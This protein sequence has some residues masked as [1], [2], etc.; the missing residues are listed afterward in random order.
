VCGFKELYTGR[1][2]RCLKCDQIFIIPA[3]DGQTAEKV[4]PPKENYDP[5]PG[6]Y[7]AVFKK[8]IPAIFN[9]QGLT[10]LMFVLLVSILKF[11]TIHLDYS[12]RIAF[13]SGGGFTVHNPVGWA[14]AVFVWG[15]LFWVY[16]EIIY[17]T[18]FDIEVLPRIDFEGGFGYMFKVF[19]SLVSFFMALFVCLLPTI[20]FRY[21]FGLLGI[22]SRWAYFPFI[23]L[24]MFLL[25]MAILTVSIGRDIMMLFRYDY[26]FS[27][28]RKA[29]RHYLFVAGFFIIVWQ[30][31][32]MSKNYGE[33]IDKSAIII[34]LNLVF[35][36]LV[37]VMLVLAMRTAGVFY[38]HFACYFKW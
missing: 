19:R 23:I 24:A 17:S 38:R 30:L 31:Q 5:L 12:F 28:I 8:S 27:P 14:V 20:V 22:T 1:R 21:V 37:Q 7:E 9:R 13:G 16:A 32:Y 10:T 26:F 2:A 11:F 29:F 3:Q 34:G 18:A 25:P 36:L 15:G 35:V 33:I 4:K 6:F